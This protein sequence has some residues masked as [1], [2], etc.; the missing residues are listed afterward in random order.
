[1]H[2]RQDDETSTTRQ[3]APSHANSAMEGGDGGTE[4]KVC[5]CGVHAGSPGPGVPGSCVIAAQNVPGSSAAYVLVESANRPPGRAA[6]A[7]KSQ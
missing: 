7:G 2:E 6:M 4:G 3:T 1:M 5:S